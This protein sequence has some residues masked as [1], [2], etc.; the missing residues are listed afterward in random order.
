MRFPGQVEGLFIFSFETGQL[1]FGTLSCL[2]HAK[3]PSA[4][5]FGSNPDAFE[6]VSQLQVVGGFLSRTLPSEKDTVF[7]ATSKSIAGLISQELPQ[8]S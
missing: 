7:L 2:R 1:A 5:L 6:R 8:T 3:L 4:R